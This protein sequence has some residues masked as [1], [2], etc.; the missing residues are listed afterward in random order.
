MQ[1]QT[2]IS[3]L[4]FALVL[5]LGGASGVPALQASA[6]YTI[7]STILS[8]HF[9][10]SALTGSFDYD[11]SVT[12]SFSNFTVE[13]DGFTLDLT[14][15]AN[16]PELDATSTCIGNKTGAAATFA[17]LDCANSGTAW[18]A[19]EDYSTNLSY[20]GIFGRDTLNG[21]NTAVIQAG[22]PPGASNIADSGI[23]TITQV[24]PEPGSIMLM[25]IGLGLSAGV[26]QATRMRR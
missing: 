10:Y 5:C 18:F 23:L 3:R 9:A 17:F 8:T 14:D 4:P 12:D 19:A 24:A 2:S 22:T 1:T 15:S 6:L 20:M 21:A 26:R 7:N 13:W 11:P 16:N 25:L